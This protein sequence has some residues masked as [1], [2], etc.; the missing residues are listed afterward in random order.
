M[1]WHSKTD[2]ERLGPPTRKEM[3]WVAIVFLLLVAQLGGEIIRLVDAFN[4]QPLIISKVLGIFS[5]WD[6]SPVQ[7][8]LGLVF[9]LVLLILLVLGLWGCSLWL[10]QWAYF[11]RR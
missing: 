8:I 6:A 1:I 10:Q 4:G 9:H 11:R 3:L 7:Y 2:L 5:T